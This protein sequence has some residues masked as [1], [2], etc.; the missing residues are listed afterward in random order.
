MAQSCG[1]LARKLDQVNE[2]RLTRD[3][4][5]RRVLWIVLG[6]NAAVA[7][8]KL[9][10]A[11][12]YDLVA[13]IA[14][15]VHSVLDGSSNVVGL[16]GLSL[17][18]RPPDAEHP[19]GH[20]R[21]ESLAA[22]AIGALISVACFEILGKVLTSWSGA[23]PAPRVT[24]S[25]AAVVA[26]TIVINAGISRYESAKGKQLQSALLDADA[27]HT[28]SDALAA[29]AVLVSF[30]GVAL[31]FTWAD[32]LG[33]AVVAV[34]VGLT[35]WRVIKTSVLSLIDSAQLPE[36]EVRRVVLEVPGVLDTH[37]IRSRG[38]SNAIALDLHIHLDGDLSLSDAHRKTHEVKRHLMASFPAVYDVVIHTEPAT[39]R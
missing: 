10:V 5:T 13:L 33:G 22:L 39:P 20:R 11:Y 25:A 1:A 24:W 17:A 30:G 6:L 37:N 29:S 23:A 21:F 12:H 18:A 4:A 26:A 3:K 38:E 27:A 28:R 7:A 9:A 34:F 8:C 35:A 32:W 14:D 36:G 19:Y 2:T 31:G 15:G 16:V